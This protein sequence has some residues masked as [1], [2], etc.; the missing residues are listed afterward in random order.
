MA[1]IT[2]EL[3]SKCGI[4]PD[5]A[6][7]GLGIVLGLFKS[8]LPE[9]AYSKVSAAVPGADNMIAAAADMGEHSGG[10][11]VDAVK[12]AIGKLF[13]G[14]AGALFAKFE[15][16]GM[17]PD[18]IQGFVSKVTEYFNGKLSENVMSQISGHLPV[19]ELTAH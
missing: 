7:K 1:D 12:G 4:S 13:G 9:V 6:Q 14:S 10:G 15:R 16:L 17:S 11:V 5:V 8:K 2:T 19:P 18:Q 3:A